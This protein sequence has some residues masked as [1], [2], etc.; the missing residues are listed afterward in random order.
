VTRALVYGL[1]VAGAATVRAMAR[2]GIDVIAVDDTDTPARRELAADLDV[3]LRIGPDDSELGALIKDSDVVVPAPGV[4]EDHRVM[5][6]ARAND[7]RLASE[8]ELAYEWEQDHPGGP[9]P[10]LAV[11]GTDGKTTTT[12]WAV[13]MLAAAGV[14]AVAAGNTE[15]PL[16]TA[17]DMDLDAFVVECTSFRLA[18]TERFRGE[19]AA[20]LNL[21]PDHLNW[22]RSMDTYGDAKNKIF[23]NQHPDDVAIGFAR[24]AEVMRRLAAAPA[25]HVT[26]GGADSDY[27]VAG[28]TLVGPSGELAPAAALRRRLPHDLTNGLAAAALVL[29]SRLADQAAVAAG[30]AAFT[31]PPHRIELVGEADGVAWY[32]DSKA[33]TPHAASVAIAGFD[34]VVL[35]AGGRNKGLDLSP[36]ADAATAGR[37]DRMRAVVAIG[38]A[39][40]VIADAFGGRDI[41]ILR[42]S[43]MPDAVDVAGAAARPGDVVLLSP[44][45]AS[46]D[47]YPDGGYEARGDHFREL[48]RSRLMPHDLQGA[49]T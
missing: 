33:T 6:A 19:A 35:I 41:P 47:W 5:H 39:A 25:R 2:R 12:L 37:A 3:D 17:I 9:R 16:V 23:A 10:M 22:H 28:D 32:N 18:L 38:E 30:L 45:C 11:T 21:A 43:S 14:R 29:E 4:A 26:F 8:I 7:V 20:W 1:A 31:G 48:V 44:G 49:D 34:H 13:E 46:F 42:A 24:D 15:V 36:M 27:R 40:D